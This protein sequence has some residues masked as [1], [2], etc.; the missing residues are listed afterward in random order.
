MAVGLSASYLASSLLP[1]D[2]P[3]SGLWKAS[4][5]ILLGAFATLRGRGLIGAGLLT[6]AIGDFLLE[7]EPPE[8]T[9][10]MAAF[11]AGHLIY[12]A[13][14]LKSASRSRITTLGWA[15]AATT[16]VVSLALALW[17]LPDMGDLQIQGLAYQA[18]ITGMTATAFLTGA[19]LRVRLGATIFMLSDSLIALD[20]YKGIQPPGG[21]VWATY[22]LAQMLLAW[23]SLSKVPRHGRSHPIAEQS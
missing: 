20:L 6:C 3:F 19:P 7:F 1:L 21:S 8:W 9:L 5:I 12:T 18:V 15:G 17:F 14:F 23:T 16:L 13:S 2:F 11:G 10:G 4:G 22:A